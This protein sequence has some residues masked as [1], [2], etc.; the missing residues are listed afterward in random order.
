MGEKVNKVKRKKIALIF[1]REGDGLYN[2]EIKK[3]DMMVTIPSSTKYS[4]LN[5][6]H[7]V[8]IVLYGKTGYKVKGE[9]T[10]RVMDIVE[11]GA[12]LLTRYDHYLGY[13]VV[14]GYYGHAGIYVGDDRVIHML[15]DGIKNHDILTFL[16]KDHVLVMNP[17][18]QD[19]AK[20][21]VACASDLWDEQV[22]Y[23]YDF[24]LGNK[25][26][27]CFELVWH[28]YQEDP[29]IKYKNWIMANNLR[30][31]LFREVLKVP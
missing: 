11:P 9:H 15:G 3:F 29:L 12:C 10:R 13:F 30:C 14:P 17:V 25:M 2:K 20:N 1:G 21:A 31:P 28:C 22:K 26:F 18:D 6:S 24:K 5:L 8:G 23:D 16:R 19:K 4:T 7:S 27:Y